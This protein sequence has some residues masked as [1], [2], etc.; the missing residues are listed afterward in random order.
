MIKHWGNEVDPGQ[1]CPGQQEDGYLRKFLQ[2]SVSF[3][4]F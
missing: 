3:L 4:Q 1:R 2:K